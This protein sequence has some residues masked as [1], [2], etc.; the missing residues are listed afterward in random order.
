MMSK[1]YRKYLTS[2]SYSLIL[3]IFCFQLVEVIQNQSD[4]IDSFSYQLCQKCLEYHF[5][6][7]FWCWMQFK[8]T[9]TSW[10]RLI[11]SSLV[12]LVQYLGDIAGDQRLENT[13]SYYWLNCL[14]CPLQIAPAQPG[15]PG[16]VSVIA[17]ISTLPLTCAAAVESRSH[18][19]C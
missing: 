15:P 1:S 17:P 2:I 11:N 6:I 18:W 10:K 8:S 4:T 7:W 5:S 9:S 12:C 19:Q 14:F 13:R 3:A 16:G